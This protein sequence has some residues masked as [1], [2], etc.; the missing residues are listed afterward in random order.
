MS[1]LGRLALAVLVGALVFL[2]LS[3]GTY[4]VSV[5]SA[6]DERTMHSS[7]NDARAARGL[8]RLDVTDYLRSYAERRAQTLANRG[9]ILPHDP[10]LR[11]GE[12]TG[13]TSTNVASI[14]RAWMKSPTHHAILMDPQATRLGCGTVVAGGFHWWTCEVRY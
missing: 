4:F 8:D 3:L 7:I 5:V 11:C 14:F 9:R 10:C 13:V 2:A 6:G 1:R 12:V